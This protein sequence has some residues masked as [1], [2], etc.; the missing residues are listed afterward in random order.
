MK[1]VGFKSPRPHQFWPAA[2]LTLPDEGEH[3][4]MNVTETSAEGLKREY[5]ITVPA[6]EVE[7]KIARRLGEIGQAV[8]VPGFRPGK[9]PM[10]LLRASATVR[11]FAAK[12]SRRR[13]RTARPRRCASAICGQR[14][15]L[16]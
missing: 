13:C 8:R 12:C 1:I 16:G 5:K 11:R 15:S 14:C 7:D 6:S 3:P 10:A 4:A 2:T 9:V